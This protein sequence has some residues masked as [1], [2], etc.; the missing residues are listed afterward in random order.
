MLAQLPELDLPAALCHLEVAPPTTRSRPKAAGRRRGETTLL[1]LGAG[2]AEFPIVGIGSSAGG[3]EALQKLLGAMP[4]DSGLAFIVAAHL[5]PTQKSHLTELLGRCTKMPVVQIE[6]SIKVK[7]NHVYVIAPDQ[8]LTIRG[9]VV[10]T[11]KPTAPRGH[12]HPVDSFF[13]SLAEDQG[14]RAIAIVL[15]GT[16][17][18]GSLGLRFIKAEGGIAIAQEPETASFQGMPRSAIGTGIVDL[19][20][21][22]DKM[23]EALLSLARHSYVREPAKAVEETAPEEQLR[24]LLALVRA[25]SKR[26]F[27][28]YKK[29]TLLR[30]IHRRMGLHRIDSLGNY[31]ERLRNDP[32]EIKAL[33]ADLTINVTGFFRDPEG[34][35][36]LTEKVIAPL[37]AE[38]RADSTIRVWVPGCSTGEEAY[39]IAILIT[40]QA[41]AVGKSFDLKLFATDVTDAVL[42]SARAGQYPGS[43]ALDVG[44]QRLERFFQMED[45]TYCIRKSLREAITF[46]PQNLLQDPPFS[47]LDLISCRN[48]L[49]YLEPE[50]QKRVLGAFHFA[51]R[52]DGHLFL[53]PAETAAGD[54]DLFQPVSKKWR[55]YRRIGPTR[56]DLVD[57]PIA[58]PA[59]LSP[60]GVGEPVA[61]EPRA[62]A[63]DMLDHALIE[64]HAPASVLIDPHYRVYY[65]RGPTEDY[66][67]PPSGEPTHNLI[68]IARPGLGTPLRTAI[69][70]ALEENRE[71]TSDA[72]VR[73]GGALHP[74]QLVVTP[75]KTGGEDPSRLMVSFFAREVPP[76]AAASTELEEPSE[77][78]LQAELD[79]AREDLRLTIEHMETSN[80]ELKASNEEI[81]SINEELQASNEELETSK[82]E[83][84][85]LNEELNTVNNQLQAK[86]GELENR[87]DD[88]NNLLNST[89]IATLFLDCSL[90]IRWF[91]PSMKKLLSLLPSDIGRPISHF[92]P[93]FSDGDL[94]EDARTVLERLQP[95]DTEVVDEL[96][97]WYIR[98]VAP[99]RTG[100]D[101][102]DGVV[103]TFT[104]ISGR[105][106]AEEALRANEERLR[107]VV[108]TDA[109]GVLFF[110]KEGTVIDANQAFLH[111][112]GY[113]RREV[114]ARELTWRTMT[115]PE[116]TEVSEEQMKQ[117]EATGRTGPYEKEYILKDGSRSWMLFVG[118]DLGDG[119]IVE[120]SIDISDRKR[121]EQERELLAAELSHRV[122]N[123]LAVVQA[124]AMQTDG[125]I[126]SAEAYREA[127]VGRLQALARAH[128]LLL[129][130]NWRSADLK[131]LVEQATTAYRVDHPQMIEVEGEPVTIT[132]KQGLGLSL[133]LHELAT[134]AV[135]YGAL[136]RHD[137]RL[138]VSWQVEHASD[139]RVR[140][141]WQ[142]R[143]GSKVEPPRE[144]GFGTQLIERACT[145]ELEGEVELDYAPEGLTWEVVF[146]L[147]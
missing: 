71:V 13:R 73:R 114:Q 28:S 126:D 68:A 138:R 7:P 87:T 66:L 76:G 33:A 55:I 61:P 129:D 14:E 122:K 97:R 94:V 80:E 147:Q 74:V 48:L 50:A 78:Q 42:S 128:G 146:P 34:W 110:D 53:G 60:T 143:N 95:S 113:S 127:F 70:R 118:A 17:T 117:L 3:L 58:K 10:K 104:D 11:N 81:R 65:F 57:F 9:G 96:G 46:A 29:S 21:P 93:R 44:E 132:P 67:G 116:W 100:T 27:N 8:E 109:I 59:D 91:T 37:V 40:E 123:T 101:R 75:L 136:S 18:N 25:Q 112:T 120:Y 1:V 103:V 77:G 92:A 19:V 6:N 45:D 99:Y 32:E 86:V 142:E 79:S 26:D 39:S 56:H 82:E 24:V 111:M 141:R 20:L 137:G 115:P 23:P 108:E 125:R 119:T 69:R 88:L 72:R 16:G 47:R 36:A 130:A 31:T 15:S 85:S 134:N 43:I 22:P 63:R 84:Q 124:L 2:M 145:F 41:E 131:A 62:R 52:E 35:K 12:R 30:R 64:R 144:K 98:H 4:P 5:D 49:I 38:R 133:V 105:K 102:I 51:L 89:D 121:A 135:K 107:K 90:Y 139:R 140:L 106:Q 83:L 54:E